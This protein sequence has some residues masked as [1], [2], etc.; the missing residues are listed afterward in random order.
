MPRRLAALAVL[1]VAGALLAT[2]ACGSSAGARSDASGGAEKPA[3][4]PSA[5]AKPAD[6]GVAALP[7]AEIVKKA[8]QAMAGAGA[9]RMTGFITD[10]GKRGR[11]DLRVTTA[12]DCVGT[13]SVRGGTGTQVI[14]I[15]K[16]VWEKPDRAAWA[17]SQDP[18][19]EAKAKGRWLHGTTI[20]DA[21]T[22]VAPEFLMCAMA[23][24]MGTAQD[25]GGATFTRAGRG[26]VNGVPVVVV[27]AVDKDGATMLSVATTGKPYLIRTAN[28]GKDAS[29]SDFSEFGTKP[30]ITEP[31]AAETVE[32]KAIVLAG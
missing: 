26:T 12:G 7:A 31:A 6:N 20:D 2:A 13:A 14:Q 28:G 10:E 11:N 8:Q 19:A 24:R 17:S 32:A 4:K 5:A 18:K 22:A 30:E 16:E 1:P 25:D 27:K 29:T 9:Y 15:G 21:L 3:A 23:A